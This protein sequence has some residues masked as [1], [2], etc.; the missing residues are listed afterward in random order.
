MIEQLVAK[1]SSSVLLNTA[2]VERL[3]PSCGQA[4]CSGYYVDENTKGLVSMKRMLAATLQRLDVMAI[5]R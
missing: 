2:R 1:D 4:R 3:S 5:E